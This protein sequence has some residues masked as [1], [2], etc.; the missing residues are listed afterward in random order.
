[1]PSL[2]VNLPSTLSNVSVATGTYPEP[3]GLRPRSKKEYLEALHRADLE[4]VNLEAAHYYKLLN[5]IDAYFCLELGVV[6]FLVCFMVQS[7]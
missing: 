1:M 4:V 7:Y 6:C 5:N 3:C 2:E